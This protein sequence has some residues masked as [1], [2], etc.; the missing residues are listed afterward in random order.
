MNNDPPVTDRDLAS[1]LDDARGAEAATQ[2]TRQRWLRQ[3]AQGDA[4]LCGVL[5][6]ATEHGHDVAIATVAGGSH[7]GTL[8][9]V[10]PDFCTLHAA[11]R[12]TLI[13]LAAVAT[14]VPGAGV[15]ALPATDHREPPEGTNFAEALA[16]RAE[17]RPVVLMEVAGRGEPLRGVLVAVGTDVASVETD[18][19]G[20][21]YVSL[22]SLAA[23]SFLASG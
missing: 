14:V 9:G 5:L 22:A 11:S 2:R 12:T 17:D 15:A 13:T 7:S 1:L 21:V 23:V 19:R 20:I 18:G 10:G 6:H 8:A 3:Q 16:E 4:R